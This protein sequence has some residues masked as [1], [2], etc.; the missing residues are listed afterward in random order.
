[1][2]SAV[3]KKSESPLIFPAL[4]PKLETG[5]LKGR[6]ITRQAGGKPMEAVWEKI[7]RWF[8]DF[9]HWIQS[10]FIG[11][12]ASPLKKEPALEPI[13]LPGTPPSPLD[14]AFLRPNDPSYNLRRLSE[15]ASS[16]AIQSIATVEVFKRVPRQ[17]AIR[18]GYDDP[19]HYQTALGDRAIAAQTGLTGLA[20]FVLARVL[21]IACLQG[22]NLSEKARAYALCSK[23]AADFWQNTPGKTVLAGA[24][25]LLAASLYAHRKGW[26]GKFLHDP[27]LGWRQSRLETLFLTAAKELR[28]R[29]KTDSSS[30][31]DL[32]LRIQKNSELIEATLHVELQ[33]PKKEAIKLTNHLKAACQEVLDPNPLFEKTP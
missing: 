32:A 7:C 12:A 4:E 8:L 30:A 3:S 18:L 29:S 33:I 2:T 6:M 26:L 10:I 22:Q 11:A 28:E 23:E 24:G 27:S 5:S 14:T 13:T 17:N 25:L 9:V 16:N 15:M 20:I 19:V 21:R 1:M 31:E